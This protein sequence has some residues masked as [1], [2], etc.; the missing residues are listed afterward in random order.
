MNIPIASQMINFP[1]YGMFWVAN[2]ISST[3]IGWKNR[4]WQKEAHER[5]QEFELELERARQITEDIKQQEEIA[6]KRRLIA[7]S[8][9]YRQ[10]E[11]VDM[12]NKQMK[13]IELRQYLQYYWPLA[14]ELP[15]LLLDEIEN[16]NALE[17]RL[18]VILLHAPL[19]PTKRHGEAND[20][21]ADI[22]KNLEYVITR[23]DVPVIHDLN[24]REGAA[25]KDQW[26]TADISGGTANI[27][28]IHFLMSQ[29]PTLIISPQY[30]NE[31]MYFNGAVWEPQ[32]AR[33]LIRPL[34]NYEYKLDDVQNSVEYQKKMI[35]V[36]HT[37]VAT[38]TGAV[39]DSYM[40][41]T[42]G[43]SP[44]LPTWLNDENHKEM[45]QIVLESPG[46]KKFI[47]NENANILN[48]LN[49]NNTT[50]LLDVFSAEDIRVIKEQVKSI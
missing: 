44:T 13:M 47:E 16:G 8:R 43:K 31:R 39:R 48:A 35:N 24:Y 38:I 4:Q 11:S 26:G 17:N 6:F 14:P 37:A 30:C 12:F 3:L 34:F 5:N 28:N 32:N 45:K 49:D 27:M 50:H 29:L 10:Q 33:P 42:Q 46:L 41:L 25:F 19:L 18:N 7:I 22:Y 1:G 40:L 23:E 20:Q 36:F 15:D 2:S 9:Q 21:D